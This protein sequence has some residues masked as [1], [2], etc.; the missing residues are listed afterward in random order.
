[1]GKTLGLLATAFV[2]SLVAAGNAQ[3]SALK[4]DTGF[5][6]DGIVTT[7]FGSE[8][9]NG[10][11]V[12]RQDRVNAIAVTPQGKLIAAGTAE[13]GIGPCSRVALVR[14][15]SDGSLDL[16]F[17]DGGKRSFKYGET[18]S[19]EDLDLLGDG[20]VQV[21]GR[22][23]QFAGSEDR[24]LLARFTEGGL[25][26]D[27]FGGDGIKNV[28]ITGH[29][30]WR[31]GLLSVDLLDGGD[32]VTSG[33]ANCGQLC[34]DW[35]IARYQ[36]DGLISPEFSEGRMLRYR[37]GGN[38]D[39]PRSGERLSTSID[40]DPQGRLV[41][42][43]P[44]GSRQIQVIRMSPQGTLDRSFGG[45][46]YVNLSV[47]GG[48][49][50]SKLALRRLPQGV[51]V[52]PD[53]G[54]YVAAGQEQ[55]DGNVGALFRL[56]PSGKPDRRFGGGKGYVETP[57]LAVNDLGVDRCGRVAVGGT[58]SRGG[59]SDFGVARYSRRGV[60][61]RKFGGV[62]RVSL[63]RGHDSHAT[64]LQLFGRRIFLSGSTRVRSGNVDFGTAA[65]EMPRKAFRCGK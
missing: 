50:K 26:D 8:Q 55:P 40:I 42:A 44:A 24:L 23:S 43:G 37:A 39:T 63:G 46:G 51:T 60:L 22:V 35:L 65:L 38:A 47:K 53:G 36:P 48:R 27:G 19:F 9:E 20:G 56:K 57:N 1:M 34:H 4:L 32:L 3:S 5:G 61:D 25:L 10:G 7:G 15:E 13:C 6:G 45:R 64:S 2:L 31:L 52:A 58:W 54:I 28:G 49:K 14:Y 12:P 30:D 17:G 59:A 11:T 16:G 62:T 29:E 41:L 33:W 18:G 21:V